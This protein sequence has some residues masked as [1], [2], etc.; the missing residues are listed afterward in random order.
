MAFITFLDS[1]E[2]NVLDN[3]Y[4]NLGFGQ[5]P[6]K[7]IT[8]RP[9]VKDKN[10]VPTMM[11]M[12]MTMMT[13]TIMLQF[14]HWQILTGVLVLALGNKEGIKNSIILPN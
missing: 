7:S 8:I 9:S 12:T 14:C 10:N 4:N 11:M 13:M 3:F 2:A 1:S 6:L 5:T